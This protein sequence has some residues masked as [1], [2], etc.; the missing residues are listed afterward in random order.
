MSLPT[1]GAWIEILPT[2]RAIPFGESLPTRGAW[3]EMPQVTA[4]VVASESLPTRGAWIEIAFPS[5]IQ[6]L[7]LSV[8][9]HT[10]SVD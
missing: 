3:I 8:A 4:S 6:K 5:R 2:V 7:I 10:G 9:P 1:R